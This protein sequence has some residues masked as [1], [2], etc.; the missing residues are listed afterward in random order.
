LPDVDQ[1]TALDRRRASLTSEWGAAAGLSVLVSAELRHDDGE[2]DALIAGEF[3]AD[4]A[5][6]RTTRSATGELAYRSNRL[7]IDLAVRTD[8]PDDFASE[9]SPRAAVAWRSPWNGTRL[10]AS[11][12]EG[13]KLPS[14]FALGEPNVG[15]PELGPEK[16]RG[17]DVTVTQEAAAAKLVV[18]LTAFRQRYADLIDFSP[19]EFRLVNRRL[20]RTWG[21]EAEAGWRPH[22]ALDLRGFARWLDAELV[23]T[24][25]TL[26]DRPRWRG[27][28]TAQWS[29]GATTG[30][31]EI[32]WVG[33]R[34]DFQIPVPERD[35][36]DGYAATSLTL[37]RRFDRLSVFARIDNLLDADY[38]EFVGFPAPG[39]S[40]RVGLRYGD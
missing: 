21:V 22:P 14:F 20:A 4:F 6:E 37:S 26:R 17:F 23:G 11:W 5:L 24:D 15:N 13:F 3:P 25:E 28:A 10:G 16:S 40:A 30:R 32:V 39:R 29:D 7:S 33:E 31:L 1:E 2:S 18:A 36:A 9:I 19:E 38:E 34:F 8:D 12:G 35:V 27:G